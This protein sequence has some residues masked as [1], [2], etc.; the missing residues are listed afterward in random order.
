MD[1][2]PEIKVYPMEFYPNRHWG[3]AM[4]NQTGHDRRSQERNGRSHD[5]DRYLRGLIG[6]S[7]TVHT[8]SSGQLRGVLE[9]VLSDAVILR[10]E[11]GQ[12]LIHDWAI[13]AIESE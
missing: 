13:A 10:T 1:T 11:R 4:G 3:Q 5:E 9:A 8:L 7:V 6:R 12:L 2:R